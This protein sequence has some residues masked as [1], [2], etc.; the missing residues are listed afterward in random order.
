MTVIQRANSDLRLNPH[1]HTIFLDG[2]YSPDG[3]GK[4]Q[5]FHP[6]PAPTQDDIEQL[7]GRASKRILR[8][9]QRR[10]VL[11][12]VTAPG[13]GEVTVVADETM[14]EK[15]PLLAR[16]LA[17][18]TA[19][20]APAGPAN[21]RKTIRIVL[22]PDDRPV[23]K[24]KLC[25]QD[26]GFNLHAATKVA[27]NDKQGR[28]TLC[29]YILRPPLA[30]DRLK[31][32]DDGNVRLQF[33]KPWSDG[34]ASV[35]LAPLA[36]IARL[37]ALVPPPKRHLTRYFGV[38][39]SHAAARSDVVPAPAVPPPDKHDK[40]PSKSTYLPWAQL[41]RKTF[42]FE[43]VCSKCQSQ[44]RLIALVKTEAIAQKILKAMHLPTQSP[45]LHPARPPRPPPGDTR[46]R[47]DWLN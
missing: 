21:K 30:N 13:D 18:A 41:L 45:A 3:D 26:H 46:G 24:G 11:T 20:A 28:L 4:G 40:P 42:G 25:A 44:L 35:D 43:I 27:A 34:T 47:A 32:L 7:V 39:S 8:F 36:F 5:M 31:I 33:K 38:L 19:G 37:A 1:L 10:A 29:K 12:L 2:V 22:D 15:D 9:L 16:L 17:A 14:G 6:A 23:A